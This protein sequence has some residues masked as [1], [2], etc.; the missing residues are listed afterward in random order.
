M[1]NYS[2][3]IVGYKFTCWACPTQAEV[4]LASGHMAY[5]RYRF[6]VCTI[7]VSPEPTEDVMDAVCGPTVHQKST[8]GAWDGVMDFTEV[9][10]EFEEA[11]FT[12]DCE[13]LC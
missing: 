6:G 10:R 2:K 13:I 11:G 1:A 8:G 9:M 4:R 5:F 7:Q 3:S 12:W